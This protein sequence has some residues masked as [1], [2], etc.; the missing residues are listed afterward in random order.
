MITPFEAPFS[1]L[2]PDPP[3]LSPPLQTAQLHVKEGD[4][5]AKIDVIFKGVWIYEVRELN[6]RQKSVTSFMNGS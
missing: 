3:T 4:G 2:P 5:C 6:F 1:A